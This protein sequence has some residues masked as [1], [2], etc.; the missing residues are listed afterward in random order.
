MDSDMAVDAVQT[1]IKRL[2]EENK[3]L[4][5]ALEAA[6]QHLDY[7]GYGDQWE[8]I[9][10]RLEKLPEKIRAALQMGEGRHDNDPSA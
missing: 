2:M 6:E 9:C 5:E 10:A 1:Q 4:R 8:R 3:V 7:C